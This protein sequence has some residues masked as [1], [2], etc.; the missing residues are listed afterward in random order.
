MPCPRSC[1]RALFLLVT[2]SAAQGQHHA[3]HHP[4]VPA[5]GN[6]AAAIR[7]LIADPTV[8]RDHWGISIRA[9][10][11]QTVYSMNDGQ[12]F[13]PASNAKIFTTAAAF[14]LLPANAVYTTNV[15]A[16]GT[17]DAAG[18]LH[19]ALAILGVGD[20]TMSGRAYP[21]GLH[22]ER[23]NPPLAALE[24]MADQVVRAGVH[25]IDGSVI[26]DDTWYPQERYAS[27]WAADDVLWLYG[28]PVSA[29]TVNDNAVFFN[30]LP[31]ASPTAQWN[32]ATSYY[33]LDN[34]ATFATAGAGAHPGL[35]RPAGS[36]SVRLFGT[37]PADGYH[38]GLAIDD[39]A[40]YAA[41]SLTEMLK[42]RGVTVSG[43]ASAR[44]RLS[45]DTQSFSLERGQFVA[46]QH[47][48]L[49][50]IAAPI[51][52]TGYRILATH[53]SPPLAQDWTVT[54]KVS[55]NL[56]AELILR[57]LGKLYGSDG[58][59]AQ[60]TRV[61]RQFVENAGVDPGDFF[62]YDGCGLSTGDL[63]T[64]RAATQLLAYASRQPWGDAYRA[65]LPVGGTDGTLAGRFTHSA[66]KGQVFAKTG[67]L[68]ETNAL[69]GYVQAASGKM[70][71][72][73]ILVNDHS[74]QS[75]ADL[76]VMDAIVETVIAKD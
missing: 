24:D 41:K 21:Y 6:L 64:P 42:A 65:S 16:E 33:T 34:T 53:N 30:V 7:K 25:A 2:F 26:G 73:S 72:F 48:T 35:D 31:G 63:I 74:P 45:N 32:P 70:L 17:V 39:P 76:A 66:A 55:Q 12:F 58:S 40:E 22:T 5:S 54:N 36:L 46:F 59:F 18:T 50:Q 67:T 43:Q 3:A 62:F 9:L 52:S 71:A 19:G 14:A 56:H 75:S 47:V 1:V 49:T 68:N 29:L 51:A 44:H 27:G 28:A 8:S 57:T 23:P 38:A 20:P 37:L 13:Q 61:V 60:G 10:D 4:A 11:G 69:S 15:I